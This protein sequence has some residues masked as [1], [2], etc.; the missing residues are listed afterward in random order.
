MVTTVWSM[1]WKSS[2]TRSGWSTST[3]QLPADAGVEGTLLRGLGAWWCGE[4]AAAVKGGW[5]RDRVG[6]YRPVRRSVSRWLAGFEL[7]DYARQRVYAA[8]PA[9]VGGH[10]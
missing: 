6:S 3:E 2:G 1:V 10:R 7:R 5:G 9:P 4:L 8:V